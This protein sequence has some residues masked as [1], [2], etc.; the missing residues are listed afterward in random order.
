VLADP[1]P[2]LRLDDPDPAQPRPLAAQA[3]I[4]ETDRRVAV[5]R[6][7]RAVESEVVGVDHVRE[8]RLVD[9]ERD[10]VVLVRG[11]EELRQFADR[12][13]AGRAELHEH[14]LAGRLCP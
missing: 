4:G 10:V 1:A 7:Q 9:L 12:E 5:P 14:S 8:P 2:S 11:G 13:L 3:E 6:D